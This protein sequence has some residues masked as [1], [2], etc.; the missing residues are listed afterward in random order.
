MVPS[1]L[2]HLV[3]LAN[4][5]EDDAIWEPE[6]IPIYILEQLRIGNLLPANGIL[7]EIVDCR[8]PPCRSVDSDDLL[9]LE[10]FGF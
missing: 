7:H 9:L 2:T 8:C 3:E 10:L 1:Q 4:P 5:G 6:I